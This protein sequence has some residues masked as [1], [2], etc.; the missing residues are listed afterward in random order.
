MTKSTHLF[1]SITVLVLFLI[2]AVQDGLGLFWSLLAA[3]G[4]VYLSLVIRLTIKKMMNPDDTS[5]TVWFDLEE[6]E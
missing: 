3:V 2:W 6:D 4:A 1:T 5:N